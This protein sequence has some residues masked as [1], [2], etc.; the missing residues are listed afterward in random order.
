[1]HHAITSTELHVRWLI[2]H[3]MKQVLAIEEDCFSWDAWTKQD[4]EGLLCDRNTIGMVCD[5]GGD[6]FGF[7]LY[8]MHKHSLVLL[9]IAVHPDYWRCGVGTELI[10]KL[11]AKLNRRKT[12]EAFVDEYNDLAIPFFASQGFK[13][14]GIARGEADQDLIRFAFTEEV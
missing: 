3:D 1:M 8:E 12:I 2:R 9:N 13:A 4:I 11:K 5:I 7:M 14:M 10:N 6:V